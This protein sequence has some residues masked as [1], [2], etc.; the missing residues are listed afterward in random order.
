[1][2]ALVG[3]LGQRVDGEVGVV[4]AGV[5]QHEQRGAWAD[6]VGVLLGEGRQR[7]SVVGAAPQ[8]G[9]GRAGRQLGHHVDHV[10]P[11]LEVVGHLVHVVDEGEGPHLGELV[12]QREDEQ[13]RELREVGHRPAHVAQHHQ[14]AAVRALGPVVGGERDTTGRDRRPDGA[15]E[16]QRS[17]AVGVVLLGEAGG[18]PAGQRLDLAPHLLQV[19][20]PHGEEVEPVD[21]GAER[22]LRDVVGALLLPDPAPRVG[23][24]L[25]GEATDAA[26]GQPV[27]LLL[28]AP[29]GH[30]AL[31]DLVDQ[32]AGSDPLQGGVRR[33]RRQP[34]AAPGHRAEPADHLDR[35]RVEGLLV[36]VAQR[37]LEALAELRQRRPVVTGGRRRLLLLLTVGALRAVSGLP[38]LTLGRRVEPSAGALADHPGEVEVEERVEGR[39]PLVSLDQRRGVPLLERG[40]VG[41]VEGLQHRDGV[42][43][44]G[45]GDGQAGRAQRLQEGDVAVQ[46][47][48]TGAHDAD[49]VGAARVRRGPGAAP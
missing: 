21:G 49:D 32:L 8:R 37:L 35:Q 40:A 3:E 7:P 22:R 18:Q 26:R 41:P 6:R 23:L 29:V 34:G 9:V 39:S 19:A 25:P 45:D 38:V 48:G 24:D 44:L 10:G 16:V 28:G 36:P 15:P 13:Q 1:M 46:Q 17:A 27:G 4:G 30:Q 11:G 20:A 33:P 5:A 47:A 12:A 14:L 43:V 31:H 2:P 42:E